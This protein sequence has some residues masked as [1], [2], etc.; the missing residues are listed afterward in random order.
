M[1]TLKNSAK[2]VTAVAIATGLIIFPSPSFSFGEFSQHRNSFLLAQASNSISFKN[3]CP[4]PIKVAIHFKNRA[5]QWET[6]AWYSLSAGELARLNGVDTTNRYLYYYAEATDGSGKAWSGNDRTEVVGGRSYNMKKFDTGPQFV[7][8]T[9]RLTCSSGTAERSAVSESELQAL[10]GEVRGA[11]APLV[12]SFGLRA[13]QLSEAEI[14]AATA[15]LVTKQHNLI[16]AY[17]RRLGEG[18]TSR[19]AVGQDCSRDQRVSREQ[20]RLI[21]LYKSRLGR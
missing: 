16:S 7:N 8:W 13:E 20:D 6:K 10:E 19:P 9:Q 18:P 1:C 21:A 15:R 14:C 3:D 17:K 5:G 2:L 11:K 12:P 4:S